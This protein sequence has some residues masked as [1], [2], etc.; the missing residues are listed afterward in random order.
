MKRLSLS[1]VLSLAFAGIAAA[2][3][4]VLMLVLEGYARQAVERDAGFALQSF[5]RDSVRRLDREVYGYL[6]TLQVFARSIQ[7]QDL[8][9]ELS[10]K[11]SMLEQVHEAQ[12]AYEWM[13]FLNTAGTVAFAIHGELEGID[14]AQD[15][16]FLLARERPYVST[17]R[18]LK[19]EDGS[20][21]SSGRRMDIEMAVP[22]S[23]D[24]ARFLG[25]LGVRLSWQWTQQISEELLWPALNQRKIELFLFDANGEP[26][27]TPPGLHVD[28]LLSDALLDRV[29]T[30]RWSDG[31]EYLTVGVRSTGYRDYPG[32]GWT[33][34]VRQ[35]VS[36]ALAPLLESK[37]QILVVGYFVIVVFGFLGWLLA[38]RISRPLMLLASMAE[39]L[40]L[41]K[42]GTMPDVR[43]YREVNTLADSLGHLLS[44]L[45]E[46]KRK[47][48]SLNS[49]LEEQVRVRTHL[50]EEANEHLVKTLAERHALIGQLETLARTDT[51]TNLPNRRAFFERAELE[52]RRADRHPAPQCLIA[53]DID[54]FK[55]IN[56]RYGHDGGD[57]VLRCFAKT[58]LATL[59]DA[60][61][62]ARIGGE[63]FMVLL[64]ETDLPAAEMV[65]E[66]LRQALAHLHVD[67]QDQLIRFTVS[68]GIA[69]LNAGENLKTWMNHADAALYYAKGAGRNRIQIWEENEP[70]ADR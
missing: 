68:L 39:R 54:Y 51:L 47:L 49:T 53:I 43:A 65:A 30:I 64:P 66:R 19:A 27:L 42:V 32:L 57:Q 21:S 13:G 18:Q 45:A 38:R 67:Y 8:K 28:P 6:G 11:R 22:V 16:L 3:A 26:L 17:A 60:D 56:D 48:A 46:E 24:E 34:L 70:P 44:R 58:A 14:A 4:A 41:E 5:A 25:V 62:L 36:V 20:E 2:A 15:K 29:S 55:K 9:K 7:A 1:F 10:L 52:M 59:R 63:E 35:P 50:L 31:E 33:V 37:R 61:L 69:R 23:G 40:L 12:P